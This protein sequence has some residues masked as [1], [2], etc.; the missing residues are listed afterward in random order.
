VTHPEYAACRGQTGERGRERRVVVKDDDWPPSGTEAAQLGAEYRL[1]RRDVGLEPSPQVELRF[2][3]WQRMLGE[4]C[5]Y[6]F[7]GQMVEG[8]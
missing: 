2:R 4:V 8:D 3:H 1:W 7:I 6:L 5:G